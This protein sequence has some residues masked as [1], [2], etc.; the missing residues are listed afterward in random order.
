MRPLAISVGF[1]LLG[2]LFL[3]PTAAAVWRVYA[4]GDRLSIVEAIFA[5]AR[6]L[7]GLAAI[8][9]AGSKVIGGV[10]ARAP[11]PADG[12]ATHTRSVIERVLA[13]FPDAP[14]VEGNDAAGYEASWARDGLSAGIRMQAKR[15][16][17]FLG[18]AEAEVSTASQAT[19]LLRGI[20]EDRYVAVATYKDDA[21]IKCYIA[22][23]EDIGAGLNNATHVYQ[24]PLALPV[25]QLRV[26][27]WSG[28]LDVDQV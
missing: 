4:D 13:N 25:D 17:I 7:I 6:L 19:E 20:F 11:P 2:L 3:V 15:A 10:V 14:P 12:S 1:F 5:G 27:S 9:L 21:L 22:P 28:A 8:G 18:I 26:R 16:T 23:V 24:G